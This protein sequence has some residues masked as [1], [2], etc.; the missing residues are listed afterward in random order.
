M[1]AC[2]VFGFNLSAMQ[3]FVTWGEVFLGLIPTQYHKREI[4]A[5][6]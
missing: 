3:R 4:V 5:F 1:G 6:E 2:R